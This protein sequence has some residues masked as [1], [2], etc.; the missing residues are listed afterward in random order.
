M[1]TSTRFNLKFFRL[2][3]KNVQ[4]GKLHSTILS[5]KISAVILLGSFSPFPV[6]NY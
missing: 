3:L 2:S 5:R 1:T 6:E 4:P